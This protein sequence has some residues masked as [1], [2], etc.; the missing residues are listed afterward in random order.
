[1]E[2]C[3]GGQGRVRV[4]SPYA[5]RPIVVPSCITNVCSDQLSEQRSY[6]EPSGHQTHH[7]TDARLQ[8]LPLRACH[9]EWHRDHAYDRQRTDETHWQNQAICSLPVL[10]VGDANYPHHIAF[11]R[12][13][14]LTATEPDD[15]YDV[16]FSKARSS[17]RTSGTRPTTL[18][19]IEKT[20]G[21]RSGSLLWHASDMKFS[22]S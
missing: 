11:V 20:D 22:D 21:Y 13:N 8:G 5:I 7:P 18:P 17:H 19:D 3:K 15:V 2:C 1:M 12:L 6:A 4:F 14:R 10:L 9:S 16:P